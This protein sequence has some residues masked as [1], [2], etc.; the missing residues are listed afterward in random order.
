MKNLI[1]STLLA[2]LMAATIQAASSPDG[3]KKYLLDRITQ[4]HDA[5]V[6][7]LAAADE[8]RA[9]IK[10][11]GGSV[12]QAYTADPK[13]MDRL[14]ERMKNDYKKMDSYGY[15][16]VEGM[17]AGIPSLVAYDVYLDSGTPASKGGDAIAPV[18][19][20][21]DNGEKIDHEGCLFTYLIEPALW[22]GDKRWV[23]EVSSASGEKKYFP[24]PD[25]IVATAKDVEKK[26]GEL[27]NDA[28]A[29]KASEEDCYRAMITMTPTF[30][31]YFDDWKESLYGN[32]K[33]RYFQAVS[34]VSDMRGI[35]GSCKILFDAVKEKVAVKD[36]A[37]AKSVEGGFVGIEKYIDQIEKREKAGPLK[38]QEIEEFGAQAK[39]K[40]D[41]LVPQIEQCAALSGIKS[42]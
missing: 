19:L 10:A 29:W 20:V 11:N 3:A 35:M 5:S 38:P 26:I 4:M 33:V 9:L 13:G 34:R 7:Y 24:K 28:A 40:A 1:K 6:D 12:Q 37:L 15:E 39:Q 23:T 22:A 27:K 42:S 14:L 16:T 8:Y 25:F 41:Q 31:G 2:I 21:L 32:G 36:K 18:V 17:V 30:S